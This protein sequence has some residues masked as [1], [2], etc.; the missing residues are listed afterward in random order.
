MEQEQKEQKKD[1]GNSIVD[2]RTRKGITMTRIIRYA[3]DRSDNH[4]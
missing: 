2:E 3:S 4:N 1:L